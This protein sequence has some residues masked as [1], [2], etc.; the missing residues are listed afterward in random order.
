VSQRAAM[1]HT[2]SAPARRERSARAFPHAP[3]LSPAPAPGRGRPRGSL[4]PGGALR[5]RTSSSQVALLLARLNPN[6]RQGHR[7]EEADVVEHQ[8][9]PK[10]AVHGRR[11]RKVG[12]PFGNLT[13]QLAKQAAAAKGGRGGRGRH[14]PAQKAEPESERV[15]RDPLV[16]AGRAVGEKGGVVRARGA[17]WRALTAARVRAAREEGGGGPAAPA[18][19]KTRGRGP[20][21][22]APRPPTRA[23]PRASAIPH[24]QHARFDDDRAAGSRAGDGRAAG[25][26]E[27]ECARVGTAARHPRHRHTWHTQWRPPIGRAIGGLGRAQ[28]PA[29]Y[30]G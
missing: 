25:C 13:R 21:A 27:G 5:R 7:H 17:T 19:A 22:A 30:T 12:K 20:V 15:E 2:P 4:N 9:E 18:R 8:K 6:L 26:G 23:R 3:A 14:R 28:G 29:G 24:I 16:V 1:L 10:L 11:R